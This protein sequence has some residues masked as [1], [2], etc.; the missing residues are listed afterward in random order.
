ML[1]IVFT[2]EDLARVRVAGGPDPFWEVIASLHRLQTRTTPAVFEHWRA[3][4]RAALGDPATRAAA[5]MLTTLAPRDVYFPDFLT[6][7]ESQYGFDAGLDALL[8]TPKRRLRSELSELARRQRLP[9]WTR[10]LA[11]GDRDLLATLEQALRRYYAKVVRPSGHQLDAAVA[12]D[13]TQLAQAFLADGTDGVLSSLGPTVRWSRPVL[14]VSYLVDRDV[15]LDGR[16]LLLVPSYFGWGNP[17]A[18]ADDSLPQVLVYASGHRDSALP[19]QRNRS[20]S[21]AALLGLT[22]ST[23]LHIVS[24][25]ASTTEIAARAEISPATA[26]YHASALRDAGLSAVSRQAGRVRHVTT[27]L[28]DQLLEARDQAG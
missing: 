2:P 5:R 7:I 22:R 25:G 6:P 18:L 28:G 16:G 14:E 11:D 26:S 1:R 23:V 27:P 3:R 13:R 9:G 17:V 24:T 21:L 12:A 10:R 19:R 4:A 20:S 15:R 8:S